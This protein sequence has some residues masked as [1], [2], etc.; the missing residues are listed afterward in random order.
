M[1]EQEGL[2]GHGSSKHFQPEVRKNHTE[3]LTCAGWKQVSERFHFCSRAEIGFYQHVLLILIN[4]W[5][6]DKPGA[7]PD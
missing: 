1:F 4:V 6:T 7:K 3:N 2:R 5:T